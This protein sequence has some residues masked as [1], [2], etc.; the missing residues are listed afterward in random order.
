MKKEFNISMVSRCFRV[1]LIL[2]GQPLV[3]DSDHHAHES[4]P[5][6]E[7]VEVQ[8][9]QHD[10]SAHGHGDHDHGNDTSSNHY[11]ET[12]QWLGNFHPVTLHFPI[13]LIVMACIAEVLL[14]FSRSEIYRY[15]ARFMI[16]A[17]PFF[18]LLTVLSGLAYGYGVSYEPPLGEIFW[19]HRSLGIAIL[20]ITI[21]TATLE[22]SR[23]RASQANRLYHPLLLVL[24]LLVCVTGYLGG[25]LTFGVDHFF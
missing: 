23:A 20:A 12:I 8:P 6:V 1:L 11:R 22:Y 7:K 15:S 2:M 13:V 18:T 16:L 21:L 3:A 5:L 19:W 4:K 25:E 10:H 24:F 17:A 14:Y 9:V